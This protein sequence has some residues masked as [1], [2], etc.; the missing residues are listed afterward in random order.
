MELNKLIE[1]ARHYQSELPPSQEVSV[2][3]GVEIAQWID[4][5]LLKPNATEEQLV[6]LCDEARQ[7]NFATVCV[8]PVFVPKAAKELKNTSVGVCTVVGFPLGANATDTKVAE[9][10]WCLSAGARELDMVI[11]INRMKSGQYQAVFDDIQS[12][13]E[14]VQKGNAKL[15][16]ILEMCYLDEFEKI[17]GCLF[18]VHAG[19][20][21]V[22]TSTGFGN[23]GATVS[24]VHLMRSVVGSP[25]KM[26]VKAAGGIRSYAD[27]RAMILAGATRIGASSSVQIV[28]EANVG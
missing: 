8:N 2:P 5:T 11:Q 26:G 3:I 1:L 17:L 10:N 25:E 20:N 19:A 24:D 18:C 14:T 7:F 13:A 21:F 16:V 23:S 27:A 22:K 9:V 15:K 28:N 12:V 4:H 6:K